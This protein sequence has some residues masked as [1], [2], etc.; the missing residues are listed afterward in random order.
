MKPGTTGVFVLGLRPHSFF[1]PHGF[2][3][4][5]KKSLFP[6]ARAMNPCDI[7]TMVGHFENTS[8][9]I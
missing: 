6:A 7:F 9:Y 1:V 2:F 5:F 3:F 8:S 4:I